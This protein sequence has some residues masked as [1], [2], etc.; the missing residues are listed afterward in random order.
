VKGFSCLL[1]LVVLAV[2][3]SDEGPT[4]PTST[5]VLNQASSGLAQAGTVLSIRSGETGLPVIDADVFVGGRRQRVDGSGQVV[6]EETFAQGSPI[7]VFERAYLDRQTAL[8]SH[9]GTALELWPRTSPTGLNE[10]YTGEVVYSSAVT[11]ERRAMMRVL[12]EASEVYLVPSDPI[13]GDPEAMRTVIVA[14]ASISAITG[15]ALEFVVAEGPAPAGGVVID[16]VLDPED[17]AANDAVALSRRRLQGWSI[18]GGTVVYESIEVVRSSTTTHE[19]GH[20]FGLGHSSGPNDVMNTERNRTRVDH[21]SA[22][23]ALVMNLMLKRPPGNELPD[24]D[25]ALSGRALGVGG[26]GWISVIACR[27]GGAPPR[28][29]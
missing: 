3:C 21:F 4:A 19:L 12:P 8:R 9:G 20:M 28:G 25:R 29:E 5:R 7:D 14:A 18:V 22:R 16:L 17:T 27:D 11:G 26:S 13:G 10:D 15:G 2:A 6:L 24:N 23:E 1:A